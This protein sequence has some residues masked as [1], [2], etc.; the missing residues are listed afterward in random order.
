M[1]LVEIVVRRKPSG[2]QFVFGMPLFVVWLFLVP[3]GILAFAAATDRQPG[4]RNQSIS[5]RVGCCATFSRRSTARRLKLRM[6]GAPWCCASP[7][8]ES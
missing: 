7:K 5:D 3:V 1:S 8:E 4:D 6:T 2:G